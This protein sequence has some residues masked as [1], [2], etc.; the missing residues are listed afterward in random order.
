M[1]ALAQ[2]T[3][4]DF[5]TI[6]DLSGNGSGASASYEVD[7]FGRISSI[8]VITSG[9][10][11]DLANTVV[12]VD[13]PRG[14]TGFQAGTLRFDSKTGFGNTRSGGGR[15][16][17]VRMTNHGSGYYNWNSASNPLIKMKAMESTVIMMATQM[18]KLIQTLSGSTLRA[19]YI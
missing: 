10:N 12:N 14:G 5:L 3:K 17:Q 19:P 16:H 1:G 9:N 18:L 4:M 15:V 13:N 8:T 6:T 11:Y 7:A 2:D